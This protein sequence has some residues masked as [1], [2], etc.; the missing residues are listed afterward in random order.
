MKPQKTLKLPFYF[1]TALTLGLIGII[2]FT[3]SQ[4]DKSINQLQKGNKEAIRVFKANQLLDEII[5]G[6][7]IVETN[8]Q[9]NKKQ[10]AN[11]IAD[12]LNAIGA[13][14]ITLQG[15]FKNKEIESSTNDFNTLVQKQLVQL[16]IE[17][18]KKNVATAVTTQEQ[19]PTQHLTD[20]IFISA[21]A[22]EEKMGSYL[23][24]N[25]S[26]NE[27]LAVRV[28]RLDLTLTLII[29]TT[30]S[31]LATIIIGYLLR[32]LRLIQAV[33]KQRMEIE[34][35]ASIKEQFLAN[36]SHEIR[37]PINSVIGFT[38]L[39]Q[40]TE[41]D[42][43]Q[44][45][46]VNMI[47]SAGENLLTIVNDI[48]DISKIE[49][50]MLHFDKSPFSINEVCYQ[51]ETLLYQKANDK[52]L[53][54]STYVDPSVPEVVVGDKERLT[55]ILTNLT[56]NAIKFTE[57][58]GVTISVNTTEKTENSVSLLFSV[59]DSGIGISGDK[60]GTIFQRFE[61]A[62]ADTTRKYGGT[63]L[64]LSI[65]KNLVE[66]QG[67]SISVRSAEGVGSEFFVTLTYEI[68]ED[69]MVDYLTSYNKNTVPVVNN[70][71]NQLMGVKILAA[72]DNKMNQMLLK[73]LF[74]QWNIYIDIADNGDIAVEKLKNEEYALVLMDIQMPVM[75]GF[76]ATKKIRNELKSGIPVIA[77]TANVLPGEKDK[78]FEVGMT[79]Y[80][81]K[82][83]NESEL[84]SLLQMHTNRSVTGNTLQT[85]N[86]QQQQ[87]EFVSN[88]YLSRIF[89]NNRTYVT[90]ITKQ[91]V[92]QYQ[93][94]LNLLKQYIAEK[95]IKAVNKMGHHMKTTVNS[96]NNESPLA[97][98]LEAIENAADSETGWNIIAYNYAFL[99]QTKA[100]VIAQAEKV[101]NEIKPADFLSVK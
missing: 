30:I 96:V 24:K 100:E 71:N 44:S 82:P 87:S 99:D 83:I 101:I 95:D 92:K 33:Q 69:V 52:K 74:E 41:M 76:T 70:Q 29:I 78:C 56:S 88:R 16:Q 9:T 40:K 22:L 3:R 39:L 20:T 85:A 60:L 97:P 61:Q 26:G 86:T 34:K 14:S 51:A 89:N 64:G 73:M 79:G 7:F 66:M 65:V 13:K 68:K 11:A 42:Q 5:N 75:D 67:G 49:A 43:K 50:G 37:T 15:L 81:S 47:Q 32:N 98:S 54:I 28:L 94:E 38:N 90:E 17:L 59:K 18:F 25:I 72:E 55:Q 6:L 48:L 2:L 77:M 27:I 10:E 4:A 58:G 36:M 23:Q 1:I 31:V 80:I 35:A 62:E 45:T 19:E 53:T 84:Y 46:F 57:R 63:G 93:Q 21:I 8:L 12:T 91:F